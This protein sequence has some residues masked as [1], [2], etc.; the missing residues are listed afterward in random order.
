MS[1]LTLAA[2]NGTPVFV[3]QSPDS[4]YSR[5]HAGSY[6]SKLQEWTFPAYPPF[7]LRV[8]EDLKKVQPRLRYTPEAE[9]HIVELA[10]VPERIKAKQLPA[11]LTFV[12]KPFDH[13]IEGLAHLWNYPRFA[14]YWEAGTGKS[15]LMIDLKRAFPDKRMLVITPKVTVQ[16]WVREASIHS[17]GRV[18]AAAI[19]G[20]AAQKRSIIRRYKEYEL[21][22]VSYGT[23]RS[24]GFPHI[25]PATLKAIQ[26]A[27]SA[28]AKLANTGVRDLVAAIRQVA[29]PERQLDYAVAWALG[30]PITHV[31]KCAAAEAA[32]QPQW[33]ADMN[34][35]IIVADESHNLN[36]PS[37]EQTKAALALSKKAAR[38]YI[39]SGTPTLGDP[40]HLYAQMKFLSPAIIP[41]DWIN[42]VST[43]LVYDQWNKHI[44]RGFKNTHI[45]NERVQ[46]ISS[47]KTKEECLDLPPRTMVNVPIT[48]SAGQ[49]TLYNKLVE[50][51]EAPLADFFDSAGVLS[52]QNAAILLNKLAQVGSGFVIEPNKDTTIC[53][54]CHRLV[55]C[56][57][58][59]VRP[60]TSKCVVAQKPPSSSVHYTAENPKMQVLE[61]LLDSILEGTTAKVIVWGNYLAELD[62]IEKTLTARKLPY[63]R[64]DG[65]T[66][67]NLQNKIDRFNNSA[68]CRVYLGQVATGVGITLN[69][70]EYMIYYSL[71]WSLGQYL[72]SIDRNYRVGQTKKVVVYRLIGEHTVDEY[73]VEAL[74][75]K[76]D[77]SAML[78]NKLSCVTCTRSIECLKKGIELYDAK[79]IYQ[80]SVKRVIAKAKVIE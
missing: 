73:K 44:V 67:G 70:A 45:L 64:V 31:A 41:E 74:E 19:T 68:E 32:L 61:E 36:T 3:I 10:E 26:A 49:T 54:N 51:L 8:V 77:L 72:Q 58:E 16:N 1:L 53:D 75:Q 38:R 2:V 21:L 79:C 69:A 40:R 56:V 55:R 46:R 6:D 27:R 63:V 24:M 13:Q 37:A 65:G 39:M 29:D 34:F 62:A 9:A 17:G 15:K 50:N 60:Y 11:G 28:G 22:A 47:R 18:K 43:F 7:G 14:T 25:Y 20:S 48:L 12:T 71:P 80:R 57:D 66:G 4:N 52:I 5:V 42:F 23:V 35:D 76:K 59:S 33:I 30:A 78:T